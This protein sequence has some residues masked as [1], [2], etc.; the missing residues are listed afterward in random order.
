MNKPNNANVTSI[1]FGN[2][3]GVRMRFVLSGHRAAMYAMEARMDK[4]ECAPLLVVTRDCPNEWWADD[5]AF[6]G[7]QIGMDEFL[8]DKQ[9]LEEPVVRWMNSALNL[10]PGETTYFRKGGIDLELWAYASTDICDEALGTCTNDCEP[11]EL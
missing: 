10:K 5:T 6:V 11:I 1:V 7:D 4:A 2:S 8:T 3:N 9:I